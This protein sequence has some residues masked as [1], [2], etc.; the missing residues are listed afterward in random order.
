MFSCYLKI[1]FIGSR[2]YSRRYDP[3][4]PVE[5]TMQALVD[6]VHQ[7]K[8]LYLG[9]SKYPPRQ[10]IEAMTYLKKN[11][12]PCLIFQDR[13]NMFQREPEKEILNIAN[14]FGAGFI[15]F[16]PLAQGVLTDKY[17]NGIP[18]HSRAAD[19]TGFLRREQVTN[20]LIEKVKKLNEIATQRGQTMAEM[21]LAWVL[22]DERVTSAIIGARNVNQIK[23]NL[24][25]LDNLSFTQAELEHINSIVNRK[26]NL[27]V[28]ISRRVLSRFF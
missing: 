13:Y 6:I 11:N 26:F 5:E 22:R 25:A 18:E 21:A 2:F 19:P 7:G 15:A 9:I 23:N 17:L 12:A 16:S 14:K 1:N 4:T 8:A 28:R 27:E 20:Q 3:H 24:K 10:A